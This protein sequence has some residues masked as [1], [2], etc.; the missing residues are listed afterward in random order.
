VK[1][2][3]GPHA[4]RWRTVSIAR[5]VLFVVH[6]V[7]SANRLTD[8]VDLF[9]SDHRVQLVHTRPDSAGIPAGI[10]E[11]FADK[12]FAVIPWQQ[13][14]QTEWDLVIT[15][16]T[17]G[18]LHEL[19]GP[20][21][22]VSHGIGYSKILS[23]SPE[24][25]A[26]SPEP[27]AVYGLSAESLISGGRIIPD[28]LVL[29]HEEQRTRLEAV[30]PAAADR[31]VVAG[32]PRFDR[33]LAS[34]GERPA[35]REALGVDEHDTLVVVSSTWWQRS[36]FGSWPDLLRQLLAELPVDRYR[37]AAI[38]HPHIWF[39]HGPAQV[40]SWLAACLRAGLIL[41]P[42]HEGWAA[43]LIAADLVL[44]DHG[45]VTTYGASIDRPVLL[46]TFPEDDV[47]A[48]TAVHTLGTLAPLLDRARPLREQVDDTITRFSRRQYAH[49]TELVSSVPGK[50]AQRL[51]ELAYTLLGLPEP[52]GPVP[53]PLLPAPA[54]GGIRGGLGFRVS[55]TVTD[56]GH[57]E[58]VRHPVD[59]LIDRAAPHPRL[60]DAHLVAAADHPLPAVRGNADVVFRRDA[61]ARWLDSAFHHHPF[62]S[63]A[64]VRR[65][66]TTCLVRT[67]DGATVHC[68][69]TDRDPLIAASALYL[70][71]SHRG[72]PTPPN[73]LLVHTGAGVTTTIAFTIVS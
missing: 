45:A 29:S 33:L 55:G 67:K 47:A 28:V 39:G 58:L 10:D 14:V 53:V 9:D 41:V 18:E 4:D 36:L 37:V 16:N 25:G 71:Q 23:R 64:V 11:H 73:S 49:V 56:G 1:A 22:V 8:L 15:A 68:Q 57:V 62:S 48:D 34:L 5:R 20:I 46:A 31:G 72:G 21:V 52:F 59:A 35:Y 54:A 65:S 70:W 42:P 26:R 19:R 6:S 38:L 50:S 63:L 7:A 69:M 61:D 17:S 12:G 13:A 40:R 66:E 43:A 32:D 60:P 24:P 2:L 27:R 44:G 51:R 3:G 30:L